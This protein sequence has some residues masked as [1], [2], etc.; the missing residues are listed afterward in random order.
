MMSEIGNLGMVLVHEPNTLSKRLTALNQLQS[1]ATV[2]PFTQ[3]TIRSTKALAA[4]LYSESLLVKQKCVFALSQ[5]RYPTVVPDLREQFLEADN[6]IG[7]RIQAAR[8]LALLR[9]PGQ[10]VQS[11]L[12]L[13]AVRYAEEEPEIMRDAAEVSAA[14]LG[15]EQRSEEVVSE[16]YVPFCVSPQALGLD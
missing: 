1:I 14:R 9:Y 15:W 4:G 11:S 5:S 16:V 10:E 6:D 13:L 2:E 3:E 12:D 7:S 8:G